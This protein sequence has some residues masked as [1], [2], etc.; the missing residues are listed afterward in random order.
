MRERPYIMFA[1]KF[2]EESKI[3]DEIESLMGDA[4][5]D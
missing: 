1:R 2:D 5:N 4:V 3:L